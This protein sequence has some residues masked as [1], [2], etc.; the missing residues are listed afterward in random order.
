MY[1]AKVEFK[2]NNYQNDEKQEELMELLIGSWRM[3]GQI[4]GKEHLW[5]REKEFYTMYLYIPEKESLDEKHHNKYALKDLNNLDAIGLTK[6]TITILDYKEPDTTLCDC[7]KPSEYILY[8][9]YTMLS[10]ALRCKKC[11][12]T[13]P[14]Y[15]IPKLY[16]DSDYYPLITWQ[17]DYQACDTLQMNCNG[18]VRFAYKQLGSFD[19][20][21]SKDGLAI[22]KNITKLTGIK[23]Y[24]Y[25]YKY[26]AKSKKQELLRK[27]PSCQGEWLLNKPLHELFDFEC[28]KCTL[29]S[30]IGW[31]KR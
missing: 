29:L 25:L 5:V 19:S 2:I 13:I 16:D 15:H 1:T 12:G 24:Y 10:S 8:T 6:P 14:L 17:S 26:V 27:C 11:F 20:Q 23:T 22:C 9:T 21:L 28:K 3:N 30:N 18:G 7:S 4:L 31:D